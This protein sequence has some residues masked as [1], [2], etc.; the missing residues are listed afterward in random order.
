[1][2][3]AV[4]SNRFIFSNTPAHANAAGCSPSSPHSHTVMEPTDSTCEQCRHFH[5]DRGL[6]VRAFE[7][8]LNRT[9]S[10]HGL[11]HRG[12]F[13]SS[14]DGMH[15]L[16]S[17]TDEEKKQFQECALD[18]LSLGPR[19]AQQSRPASILRADVSGVVQPVYANNFGLTLSPKTNTA[20]A[21]AFDA[22]TTANRP[23]CRNES[24]HANE[25]L[26]AI[27]SACSTIDAGASR[28]ARD[29]MARW[30]LLHHLA[31]TDANCRF[32]SVATMLS[33]QQLFE[34]RL[35]QDA[36]L[37]SH[38]PH[39]MPGHNQISAIYNASDVTGLFVLE[40]E[41]SHPQLAALAFSRQLPALRLNHNANLNLVS[42][43]ARRGVGGEMR[44]T[45]SCHKLPR[46]RYH[47]VFEQR[48]PAP[49]PPG[50]WFCPLPF[51][52]RA[53]PP[54]PPASRAAS[55]ET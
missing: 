51:G 38:C 54:A 48:S 22:W 8:G 42:F 16:A 45:C 24:D 25:R 20:G 17:A 43:Q 1:M 27:S 26:R 5:S 10:L 31:K 33:Q 3:T 44:L 41:P 6:L 52:C 49:P 14:R 40:W 7:C 53:P 13:F 9:A 32:R 55:R 23:L 39:A 15:F 2:L 30:T 35:R 11:E 34:V 50:Q 47:S 18:D 29:P 28:A 21:Y 46:H 12:R 37:M 4:R 36:E 19:E